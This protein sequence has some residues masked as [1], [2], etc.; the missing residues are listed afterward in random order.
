MKAEKTLKHSLLMQKV[1]EQLQSRF[2]P[3]VSVIKVILL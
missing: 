3:N 1:I 2:K